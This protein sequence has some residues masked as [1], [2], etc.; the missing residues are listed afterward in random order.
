GGVPGRTVGGRRGLDRR[1]PPPPRD[2][3]TVVHKA[4]AREPGDRYQTAGALAEDLRR[5]L[6]D[7][8]VLARRAGLPERAWRWCRRNPA[9]AAL[10]GVGG[11]TRLLWATAARR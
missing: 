10:L 4:M 2:L 3:V 5:F 9:V 11:G 1:G 7:R 8:P 6:D